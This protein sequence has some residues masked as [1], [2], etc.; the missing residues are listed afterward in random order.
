MGSF[1]KVIGPIVALAI[2]LATTGCEGPEVIVDADGVRLSELDLTGAAPTKLVLAGPDRVTVTEGNKL[3]ITVSGDEQAAEAL[4]FKLEKETLA[5]MRASNWSGKG[6]A[7]IAVTMPAARQIVL[8]GSGSVDAPA[9]ASEAEIVVAGSGKVAV[10]RF[11][12]SKLSV[13]LVGSG[14]LEAAGTA[15]SLAFN[16]MGSGR[17]DGRGLKV[18]SAEINIAGSGRGEFASDGEVTANV[19]GSGD[20]TVRGRAD[21]KVSALG[22]GRLRCQPE[23]AD[24]DEDAPEAPRAPKSPTAPDAPPAPE[25]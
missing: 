14:T 3:A 2:G 12:A 10:G 18:D 5:I 1:F 20:V 16:I 19:A 15:D 6:R 4:R 9:M 25:A 22:S 24:W 21:C 23:G 11:A 8:A 7:V 17:L 13:N